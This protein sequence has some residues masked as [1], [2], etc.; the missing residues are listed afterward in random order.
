MNRIL[1]ETLTK[2]TLEIHLD[3]TKLLLTALLKVQALPRKL[4][5]LSPFEIMYGRPI[6]TPGV[7]PEP[8]I[9]LTTLHPTLLAKLCNALRNP[10]APLPPVQIGDMVICLI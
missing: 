7:L 8:S 2:L 3:W 4:F 1:K 5:K 10:Q 6:V 9:L